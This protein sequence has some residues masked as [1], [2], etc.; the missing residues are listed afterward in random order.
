MQSSHYK[1]IK[2]LVT[3]HT[4]F[5]GSWLALWL[6]ELGAKVIGLSLDP[7]TQH[8]FFVR[9]NLQNK[10][11]DL[12]G[13]IN[14]LKGLIDVFKQCEPEF[15]FHLAAQPIVRISYDHP[16]ETF[17]TNALGTANVLEAIRQTKSVKGAVMVTTD[18]VYRDDNSIWG[19]REK[20][21]L[22]G[23]DPYSSSKACAELIIDSYR[24]SFF[25]QEGKPKIASA[26]AG[27]VIGGGD[28][29]ADR[30]V[31][32]AIRA[33]SNGKPIAL[34]NPRSIR[35]WQHV[36]DALGGYLLLGEK[37]LA[38]PNNG[39]ENNFANAWNFGPLPDSILTVQDLAEKIIS[40]WGTGTIYHKETRL[41]TKH[42][43]QMLSLDI[44]KA[45]VKL[46]WH[47]VLDVNESISMTVEWYKKS[48]KNPDLDI[49]AFSRDQIDHFYQIGK[50]KKI[51]WIETILLPTLT[52]NEGS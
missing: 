38:S 25:S 2:V 9:T 27:N 24:N 18:K 20:D 48:L 16:I 37:L 17:Q 45:M 15:V 42:E 11:T 21:P 49:Y 1:G 22:G 44:T 28:W 33:L 30:L 26:R 7:L 35:P 36:L 4:G 40:I 31:P 13:D 19:Y 29:Q 41:D 46:G 3:G 50:K 12:R 51:A 32:D 23:Y 34:R 5:K 39:G 47:P 8:D 52:V 14:N 6:R 10:I 43:A